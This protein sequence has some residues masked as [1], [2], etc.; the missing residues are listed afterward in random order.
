MSGNKRGR[1]A[2]SATPWDDMDRMALSPSERLVADS[3]RS[4]YDF[5][6]SGFDGDADFFNAYE[7][8][9]CPRCGSADIIRFGFQADGVRRWRCHACGTTF[10][11]ATGTIFEDRKLPLPAWVDFMLQVFSFES[12]NAM[13]REDRRARTTHPY[14][15]A[16]LF[17][18]LDGIQDDTVLSGR[19]QVDETL[20]PLALADQP[21]R[22]DGSKMPGGFSKSKMSIGI[23]CDG[24]RSVFR[25]L[26]LGRPTQRAVMSEIGR[27]IKPGSRLVHDG[28]K[29]H[30][31]L[32]RKLGLVNEEH[33]ADVI[34]KLPDRRNPLRDVNRL[35]FLLKLFLDSHSGFDRGN[36][37]GY[38]N[39]FWVMMNPPSEKME[40]A[41]MVLDLAMR[42][43]TS[44][45]Y[46]EFYTK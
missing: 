27:H 30:A 43:T 46:R 34:K 8:D 36:I 2:P 23:G 41:A 25:L 28:E 12:F 16:K 26:G 33:D 13:T 45:R 10:T 44:L 39:V 1:L 7:R 20:Y 19:V 11:P 9:A 5:R 14:W 35:C 37:D 29:S 3:H 6:H 18:V 32:V 38:L 42:N 21:R 4:I 22:P 24:E 40:K 31:I 17:A 15:A